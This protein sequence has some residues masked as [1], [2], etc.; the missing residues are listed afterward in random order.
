MNTKS[1]LSFL[2][3]LKN[4]SYRL[5]LPCRSLTKKQVFIVFWDDYDFRMIKLLDGVR[6]DKER[7][8]K[9]RGEKESDEPVDA[10]G[11]INFLF[12]R[13]LL[14]T[15]CKRLPGFLKTKVTI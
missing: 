11:I 8:D 7:G 12:D 15:E 2:I 5:I 6:G 1:G 9:E 4:A 3:N 13:I 14:P 10:S